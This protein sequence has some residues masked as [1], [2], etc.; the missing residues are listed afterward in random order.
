MNGLVLLVLSLFITSYS[1]THYNTDISTL[2]T[3]VEEISIKNPHEGF[4]II[5]GDQDPYSCVGQV[6]DKNGSVGSAVAISGN[7]VITAGHCIDGN[8][9]KEFRTNGKTY[10]IIKQI[11]HPNFKVKETI[12]VDIGIL[13]L[14]ESVCL[15]SYPDITGSKKDLIRFEKLVTVGFSYEVKKKSNSDSFFYYGI[16]ENEPL[17]IIFN[18]TK[19]CHIWFG[20]SG[21]AI[22][23][24]G[25][26]MV[27]LISSISIIDLTVIEMSGI[28][29]DI[30]KPWIDKVQ[31]ENKGIWVE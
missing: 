2:E 1:C 4:T 19:K 16:L 23:E 11:L 17:Y 12:L 21:G 28:R 15:E 30:C 25:G 26:K 14:E 8:D 22:F 24:D 3:G 20:D 6:F 31:Q 18:S 13:I 9:L 7:V 10:K 27:A 5:Y 29:L